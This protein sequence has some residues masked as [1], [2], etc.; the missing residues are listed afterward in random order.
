MLAGLHQGGAYDAA[1]RLYHFRFRDYSP[2]LMRWAGEDPLGYGDG[3][4]LYQALGSGP[5]NALD[6]MG[7]RYTAPAGEYGWF[8]FGTGEF[9]GRGGGVTRVPPKPVPEWVHVTLDLAGVCDPSGVADALNAILYAGEGR[10]G[11]AGVSV[12]SVVPLGD[13]AKGVR[14]YAAVKRGMV[15]RFKAMAGQAVDRAAKKGKNCPCPCPPAPTWVKPK[16]W[17]LPQNGK[18]SGTPGDSRFVPDNPGDLGLNPGD[19]VPFSQGVPNFSRWSQG[20]HKVQGLTGDHDV[21]MSLI[22]EHIARRRGLP[23]A[24]AA[25]KWLRSQGLTPHHAGGDCVQLVPT[26]LHEGIRHSGGA[27]KLRE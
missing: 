15:G 22:H 4:S 14:V 16:G 3:M 13:A 9:I 25:K 21:D 7:L 5:G 1:S 17:H 10:L 18:W 19:A 11:E 24:F 23:N 20:N 27:A 2:A 6:P 8:N 26:N 12:L